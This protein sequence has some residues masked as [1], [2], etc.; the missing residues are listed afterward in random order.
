MG[1][2][3]DVASVSDVPLVTVLP[4][5]TIEA[6]LPTS[7]AFIWIMES[8]NRSTRLPLR[9]GVPTPYIVSK[10]SSLHPGACS[11]NLSPE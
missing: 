6:C 4:S 2:L 5:I 9:D 8:S 11:Y 3:S 7:S 10:P 1:E